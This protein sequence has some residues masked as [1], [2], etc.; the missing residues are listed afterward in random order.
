MLLLTEHVT[1]CG[2]SAVAGGSLAMYLPLPGSE[3]GPRDPV[4]R[5]L[6]QMR[7]SNESEKLVYWEPFLSMSSW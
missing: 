4:S 3:T 5:L 7:K 2:L 1:V 6:A